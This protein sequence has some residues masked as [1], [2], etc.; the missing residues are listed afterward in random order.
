MPTPCECPHRSNALAWVT[1]NSLIFA[2][3]RYTHVQ[4]ERG[5]IALNQ[6]HW[7]CYE[8]ST[9]TE[10]YRSKGHSSR[11]KQNYSGVLGRVS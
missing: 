2:V 9:V 6:E 3:H 8:Y 10:V 1:C 11:M 5:G 4:R 7:L